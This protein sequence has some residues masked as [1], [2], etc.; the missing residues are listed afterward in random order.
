MRAATISC[1]HIFYQLLLCKREIGK[2]ELS[3]QVPYP[4]GSKQD[5]CTRHSATQGALA[6]RLHLNCR[7]VKYASGLNL[8]V[9]VCGTES[10]CCGGI[11]YNVASAAQVYALATHSRAV[12]HFAVGVREEEEVA[13]E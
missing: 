12:T 11:F 1:S 7:C 3:L 10:C 9:C 6:A 13:V 2:Q 8:F 4:H 5:L